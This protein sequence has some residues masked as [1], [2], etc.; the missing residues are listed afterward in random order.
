MA[1]AGKDTHS[2]T[3][4]NTEPAEFDINQ[5][6][7][8]QLAALWSLIIPVRDISDEARDYSL[9]PDQDELPAL[10]KA[11]NVVSIEK[12]NAHIRV[13]RTKS[14]VRARGK[15]TG[16]LTQNCVVS[17][18]PVE[19]KIY[20]EIDRTFVVN[21]AAADRWI[22]KNN[23]RQ[24]Q[25]MD[26]DDIDAPDIIVDGKIDLAAVALEHFILGINL[27]PRAEGVE[28]E[29][30]PNTLSFNIQDDEPDDDDE[31]PASPFAALASL[32]LNDGS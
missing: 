9:H 10:A 30:N 19:E 1:R 11:L 31:K 21:K 18:Q 29:D 2:Q 32:K 27:Y 7:M 8:E 26:A 23:A 28:L 12:I 3:S 22:E 24:D 16:T 13:H 17:L 20:E 25:Y 14:G 15:V 4:S 6:A 5:K